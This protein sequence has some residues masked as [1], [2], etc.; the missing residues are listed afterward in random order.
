VNDKIENA[1]LNIRNT[2]AGQ[3]IFG[4][5]RKKY[6]AFTPEELVRQN[7]ITYFAN[8]KNYPVNLMHVDLLLQNKF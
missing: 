6:V 2:S 1:N 5:V 8:V 4:C 7:I 3:Q